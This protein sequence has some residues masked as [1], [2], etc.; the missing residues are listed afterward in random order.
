[1]VGASRNV[2]PDKLVKAAKRL[3]GRVV[4]SLAVVTTVTGFPRPAASRTLDLDKPCTR[5][6]TAATGHPAQQLVHDRQ[7]EP[8]LRR[9][10]R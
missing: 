9:R 4:E 7:A 6:W 1:M 8:L 2:V 3:H 10:E 5:R